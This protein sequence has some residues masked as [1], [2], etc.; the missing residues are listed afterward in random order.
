MALRRY[1]PRG[2]LSRPWATS[3]FPKSYRDRQRLPFL[4]TRRQLLTLAIE[5]SCDDTCVAILEKSAS[6]SAVLHFNEKVSLDI[7]PYGGVY[8][9]AAVVL[10]TSELGPLLRKALRALPDVSKTDNDNAKVV[11][12]DGRPRVKPDFVT[13]TRGPGMSSNLATGLNTAKGL[14]VAWDVPLVGVNH[15]Q[16]HALTPRLVH[17]LELGR[18]E[19]NTEKAHENDEQDIEA[20][21]EMIPAKPFP[22]FPF[23]S[24]LVSGGHSMLVHSNSLIAHSI[25]ASTPNVAI[26]DMLDK[27]AR[28]ILPPS[29]LSAENKA[30]GPLLEDFAFP[31]TSGAALDEIGHNYE[32]QPPP[33]RPPKVFD[34][35]FGWTLNVPL[36]ETVKTMNVYE[37]AGLNGQVQKVLSERP[38]MGLDER[39]VLARETMRIAFEHLASRVLYALRTGLIE[40]KAMKNLSARKDGERVTE[41]GTEVAE[42]KQDA[43]AVNVEVEA[44]PAQPIKTVVLSGGVASN[45]FLRHIMRSM[46][47]NAGFKD[48]KLIAPPVSLCTDNAAMIAW[49]GMEMY[50]QGWHTDLNVLVMRPWP[51]DPDTSGGG[52]LGAPG[53]RRREGFADA[54][55]S[56]SS[57]G[58]E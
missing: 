1:L 55:S 56:L 20:T 32:Y 16:A 29:I 39:R 46:L 18:T 47:D 53:W 52:I 25:L 51:V 21:I 11:W 4:Q 40:E 6:G 49:T 48:V 12:V 57:S 28:S 38:Q 41:T 9:Q 36:G 2:S 15:M 10:H 58:E 33:R 37:F 19:V 30:Y 23:L 5:S 42:Q 17:A 43:G 26:G 44:T 13:V 7:R 50:E 27:C 3:L 24:L 31:G 8:P 34:S 14:S 45:N 22:D 35:G 54:P